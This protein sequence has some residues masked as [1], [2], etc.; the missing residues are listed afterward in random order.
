MT[1]F[2]ELHKAMGNLPTGWKI[3]RDCIN[4]W[5]SN[6]KKCLTIGYLPGRGLWELA[7]NKSNTIRE[8][9]TLEAALSAA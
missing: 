8:F 9:T 5:L 7:N 1:I 4:F 2:D 6:N 3:H